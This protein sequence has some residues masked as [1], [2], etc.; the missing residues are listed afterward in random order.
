[1]EPDDLLNKALVADRHRMGDRIARQDRDGSYRDRKAGHERQVSPSP[2]VVEQPSGHPFGL[3]GPRPLATD[4]PPTT[5]WTL[6]RGRANGQ[7][8][9]D[10]HRDK[11]PAEMAP[12]LKHAKYHLRNCIKKVHT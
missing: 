9:H 10:S 12:S 6:Y 11:K 4:R 1:M 8:P 2:S 5:V 3:A 7:E